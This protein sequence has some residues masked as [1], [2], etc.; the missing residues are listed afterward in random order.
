MKILLKFSL[1]LILV[2]W[3]SIARPQPYS[4]VIPDWLLRGVIYEIYPRSFSKEGNFNGITARLDEL[5]DLGVSILWLMPIHPI[6]R[7]KKKG[8]IGSP[9]AVRDYYAINPDYGTADDLK[10]LVREAHARHMQVIIDIVANHTS[11]DNELMKQHPEFYKRDAKGNIIS[12]HDWYD[13]AALDYKNPEL[14]RYMIDMLKYWLREFNLDGFRCDVAA[15]VPTDFWESARAELDQVKPDIMMLAEAHKPELHVKAFDIDYSWP[16]HSALREVLQGRAPAS[17][18]RETWEKDLKEWPSFSLHMRFSDNHDERRLIKRFGERPALAA[19]ALILLMDGVPMLYNGMEVGD[20][21]ESGAP[22]LF[23]KLPIN[24][25]DGERHPEIRRFYKKL[26]ATRRSSEALW[27]G[28]LEWV[29]NSDESRV[30]SF[31]RLASTD[32]GDQEAL[33][34]INL[35]DRPFNG[36]VHGAP[37]KLEAW[38]YKIFNNLPVG[39]GDDAHWPT[40]AKNGFGTA[41]SS[42]SKVWFTLAN[43]VMTE[44]FAPTIDVPNVEN[45]Q[46]MV[47]TE[48]RVENEIDDTTHR[49]ELPD[50]SSL[51][52]RQV[53]TAKSGQYTIEKTYVTDPRRSTVLIDLEVESRIPA[54]LYLYY[55]PSM[56]DSGM[57]DNAQTIDDELAVTDGLSASVLLTTCGT[58]FSNGYRGNEDGLKELREKRPLVVRRSAANGNVVQVVRLRQSVNQ[59]PFKLRCT[60]GLGFEDT[61]EN[62]RKAVRGSLRAGFAAVRQ[63]YEAGWREYVARLPRVEAKYQREF[64]MA[65]MVLRGLEDKR[66]PG[67]II[68]S[69]SSPWGGGPNANEPTVTGYHAFWSR[70]LYHIAT[71]FIALGD[72][73]TANRILDYLFR[74]QQRPDGSFPR[75]TWVGGQQIGNALQMDQVAL[76]LVLAYQ[77]KRTD[78]D[79]WQKHVKPAADLLVRRGPQTNQDRWEEKSGYF[80][81]TVAAEIAGLVC[82]A[83]IAKV[84]G[85]TSSANTYLRI[86]DDWARNIEPINMSVIDAGFLELVRLGI[87]AP[88]DPMIVDALKLVD[89]KIKVTTPSGDAWYRYNGDAYGE[90]AT[91]GDF[92]GRNGIGRLWTLL[93]GERGEYEIAVGDLASARKRLD[94][95][96]AFAN[97]GLMIPEQVWDRA[98]APPGFRFGAGTGS[99]TPLAWSMAQFIRLAMNLKQGRN[100]ETPDV[101]ARR[102]LSK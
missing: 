60:I 76:P 32:Y 93:T 3:P 37:L 46:L 69:P 74:V 68:A 41:F 18:L 9:Y 48:S 38:E 42:A 72:R 81:A 8:T 56:S 87:K 102:Y 63:E 53:N 2:L 17:K 86:A 47:A 58:P 75:N 45:L 5:K 55:D 83:E 99:A 23:E 4:R 54:S 33:V 13:V 88:N 97:D 11:W 14:R 67:A 52:F 34:A 51:T 20:T 15:E 40:A 96:A 84:N 12:P 73:A 94:T 28:R 62:A 31:Q 70:D 64:N 44:V 79:T 16:L 26:I 82:A 30:V 90:T 85:D 91:G 59:K 22:E 21:T 7:E 100:L 57:H 65:A 24:W 1:F 19:S 10:L 78:R 89:E 39:P 36:T 101:V 6:G 25:G 43:G 98:E 66:F 29:N 77:L 80:H 92:D 61:I 49:M 27:T 35:S 50:S 95:L 71:A